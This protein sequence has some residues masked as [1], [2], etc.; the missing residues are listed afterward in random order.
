MKGMLETALANPWDTLRT[1]LDGP[2]HPGGRE[3]TETLLD[4]AEVRGGTRLVD[5]GCGAGESLE[6]ARDRGADAVGLDRDQ[7]APGAVR[8]DMTRLPFRDESVEVVLAECVMCLASNREQALAESHRIIEP[9]GFLAVSDVV[10]ADSIPDIPQPMVRALCLQNVQSRTAMVSK[11]DAAGFVVEDVQDHRKD[12]I[13][14]RDQIADKINYESMLGLMGERGAKILDGI[15]D[16]EEAVE[17]GRIS[18]VSVVAQH[19]K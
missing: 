12:L 9:G 19:E 13:A 11:I 2:L 1:V 5:V 16:T 14:M 6:V 8:G 18:Y 10:V 15:H 17:D 3:A 4:R 7:T